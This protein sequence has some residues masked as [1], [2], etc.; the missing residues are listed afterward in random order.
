M[1]RVRNFRSRVLFGVSFLG[2]MSIGIITLG[3]IFYMRDRFGLRP[4][5]IG[6][7]ASVHTLSYFLGCT[8]GK[9]L[10]SL[11]K[12]RQAVVIAAFGMMSFG[13]LVVSV[14]QVWLAFVC[15]LLY[16]LSTAFFWPP[17]MGW[18]TRG[19]EGR[20]L[21][22]TISKFNLA[23]S[24]GIILAPYMAGLLTE[25]HIRYPAFAA[26]LL[27]AVLGIGVVVATW[28][29][30]E[31]KAAQS[32]KTIRESSTAVD[33]STPLRFAC[34]A[35][36]FSC[37]VVFGITVNIFPL[38]ARDMLGYSESFIGGILLVRG[39]LTTVVFVLL[40]KGAWWHFR[41]W[42]IVVQQIALAGVCLLGAYAA[43]I[44]TL[45]VFFILFGMLFA[46][47]YTNSIFHGAAGSLDRES[48]MATHEAMLTAGVIVGASL[49]GVM[50]D[51]TS[52][53]TLMLSAAAAALLVLV[54]QLIVIR[55]G[56]QHYS[57]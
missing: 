17:L 56:R 1:Q 23:W 41:S 8:F 45:L 52:F 36:L 31:I 10:I 57:T 46:G 37:Y 20:E 42:Q 4:Q 38:Y 49:G 11:L 13:L 51:H 54:L 27:F 50:Y 5:I 30:P 21:S 14:S 28:L 34:W 33:R 55:L 40:G 35:G 32:S 18:L 25:E 47:I 6:L 3:L 39:L 53:A 2:Q 26:S 48:R 24:S 7:F 9:G 12:P 15:Y 22:K 16:G 43:S 19:L 29:V 44:G